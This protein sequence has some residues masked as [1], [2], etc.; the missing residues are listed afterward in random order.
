MGLLKLC[1]LLHPERVLI[2]PAVGDR[3]ELFAAFAEL[4]EH[5]GLVASA[6]DVI[7]R[8]EE[9]EEILS[10]GI[11]RGIAVPHAQLEGAGRLLA[12]ASTHPGGI[13]YPSL[14]G[15]PV[16]LAFCLVGDADTAPDHLAGLARIARLARR[17]DELDP[18]IHAPTPEEF[19]AVLA[20][21]EVARLEGEE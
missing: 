11:G 6:A 18:L 5:E 10:T 20:A 7:A 14:D 19:L 3:E 4:F 16:R 15:M 12:A 2:A 1:R 8:L 9:R 17:S 21:L 13:P